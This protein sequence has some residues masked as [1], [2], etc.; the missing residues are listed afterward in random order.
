MLIKIEGDRKRNDFLRLGR[1]VKGEKKEWRKKS[2][3]KKE[4]NMRERSEYRK[5]VE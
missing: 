2:D 3:E 1:V 5:G 4:R